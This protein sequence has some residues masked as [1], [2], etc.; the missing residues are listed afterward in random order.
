MLR[1]DFTNTFERSIKAGATTEE[2]AKPR[3]VWFISI[4][5]IDK[6]TRHTDPEGDGSDPWLRSV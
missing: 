4:A 5:W 1:I 3:T 6:K 2:N